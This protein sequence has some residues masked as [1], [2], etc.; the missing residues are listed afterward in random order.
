MRRREFIAGLGGAAAWPFAARAQQLERMR[1][2]GVLHMGA[3]SDPGSLAQVSRLIQGLAELGWTDGGNLRIDVR[4]A[5]GNVDRMRVLAKELVE[6]QP[7]VIFGAA[8]AAV[9]AAKRETQTIPIDLR[10]WLTRSATAL[11]QA[12][13][14]PAGTLPASST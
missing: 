6:R 11:L 13:R 5:G 12:C 10:T 4:W 7:E 2:I 14:V 9:A 1:R 3:E 8:S